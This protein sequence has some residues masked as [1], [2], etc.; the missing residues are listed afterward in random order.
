ML[1]VFLLAV[2]GW[3]VAE[4]WGVSP[5]ETALVEA[6]L[7][8][9]YDVPEVPPVPAAVTPGMAEAEAG[10]FHD[11]VLGMEQLR[12]TLRVGEPPS[13]WMGGPYLSNAL[14]FPEVR[15]FW[16]RYLEY[17]GAL[18]ETEGD[19]FRQGFVTRMRLQG[20]NGPVLS[21]RLA[22]ALDDFEADAPRREETYAGMETLA[23]AALGLHDFLVA[24]AERI[25]YAP[26]DRG[27][28]DDPILEAVAEDPATQEALWTRIE[29]LVAALDGVADADPLHRRDVSRSVLG[30]LA[31]PDSAAVPGRDRPGPVPDRR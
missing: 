21:I 30:S 26:V 15:E 1:L 6:A 11:M 18:R 7:V 10:A 20:V 5:L 29:R 23:V 4:A 14:G 3:G 31:L 17:V 28:D 24:N 16:A 13:S 27:I 19:L 25:R 2:G 8:R 9:V 22:R 12:R